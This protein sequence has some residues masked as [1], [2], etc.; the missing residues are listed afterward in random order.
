MTACDFSAL[1]DTSTSHDSR[2]LSEGQIGV[3]VDGDA[4]VI[5][6]D[7]KTFRSQDSR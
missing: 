3:A 6:T 2:I 7:C 1:N 4:V 5:L